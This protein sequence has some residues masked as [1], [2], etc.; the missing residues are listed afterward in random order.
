M[1]AVPNYVAHELFGQQV[2]QRLPEALCKT[3]DADQEAFRCGLYGPDPLLFLPGGAKAAKWLHSTWREKA[4]PRIQDSLLWGTEGEKS[5]AT[6]YLCH[7]LLDDVCHFQI[8][9]WMEEGLSHR[10]LEVGLDY[11][12]LEQVG[13]RRFHAPLVQDKTRMARLASDVIHPVNPRGYRLGL[14]SMTMLCTQMN[15]VGAI[16]RKKMKPEYQKPILDLMNRMNET[17]DCVVM[18]ATMLISG[19]MHPIGKKEGLVAAS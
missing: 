10:C 17:V 16:Y 15:K 6:G 12:L 9:R 18:L 11:M 8:Y 14:S 4:L 2:Q 7:M 19:D 1:S 13:E 3:V 5:F